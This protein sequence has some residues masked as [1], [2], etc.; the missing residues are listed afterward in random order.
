MVFGR[1]KS[2][3]GGADKAAKKAAKA[4]KKADKKALKAG[5]TADRK[6]LEATKRAEAKAAKGGLI[7]TLTDPKTARRA[8]AAAKIAGPALA[9]LA[10]KASTGA[11]GFL[12]Q[13]RAAKLGVGIS[14]VAEFR[15][16]TGPVSAR[17]VGLER[18]IEDLRNR[19]SRDLQVTRFVQV[20]RE[21][22]AD[23]STAVRASGSMPPG[24]RRATL[25]AVGKELGQIEAD[26]MTFLVAA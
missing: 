22:L 14:E 1:K 10:L 19:R 12:D 3:G 18:S 17:I 21:R 20:A 4:A 11:R 16:P 24:R 8:V 6:A 5:K 15:G 23:L 9:P 2:A 7:G 13:R 25:H 26:L